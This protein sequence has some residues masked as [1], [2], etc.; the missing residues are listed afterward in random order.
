MDCVWVVNG[1]GQGDGPATSDD[2]VEPRDGAAP[3]LPSTFLPSTIRSD[4][5]EELPDAETLVDFDKF[6]S[7]TLLA[8]YYQACDAVQ[9]AHG[10]D[11][12]GPALTRERAA[13]LMH[14]YY[15]AVDANH[16]CT[17][18]AC[19]GC[20]VM[21]VYAKDFH[22]VDVDAPVLDRL[23]ADPDIVSKQDA[24]TVKDA[25]YAG[26]LNVVTTPGGRFLMLHRKYLTNDGSVAILCASC[27]QSLTNPR[28]KNPPRY[29][30][31]TCN[32]GLVPDFL[33]ELTLGEIKALALADVWRAVIK[34][35]FNHRT[36]VVTPEKLKGHVLVVPINAGQV[37]GAA[38]DGLLP[39]LSLNEDE[40]VIVFIGSQEQYQRL[41]AKKNDSDVSVF[42]KFAY[43]TAG[44][45]S[46]VAY[47]YLGWWSL[48]HTEYKGIT[49]NIRPRTE[50]VDKQLAEIGPAVA[51]R[52]VVT[53]PWLLA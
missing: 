35:V 37:V 41:A 45:R 34:A 8:F 52:V 22:M 14:R 4:M 48:V 10:S 28:I 21:G 11:D 49:L 46:A 33:P 43:A 38:V 39:R 13:E 17:G 12:P 36:G 25:R 6:P 29:S 20:F 18:C 7:K 1:A 16:P 31:K 24:I 44:V 30:L 47:M 26:S 42:E 50:D 32:F 23:V 15:E 19:C 5:Y 2:D 9:G 40:L 53:I 3:A 27:H 51:R